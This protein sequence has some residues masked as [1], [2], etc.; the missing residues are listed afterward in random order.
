MRNLNSFCESLELYT[1][2]DD[3]FTNNKV[4]G[5]NVSHCVHNLA[6]PL[7]LA[8]HRDI[9]AFQV[10]VT[11]VYRLS[12]ENLFAYNDFFPFS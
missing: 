5:I 11:H 7:R 4:C 8:V 1:F 12:R 9:P 6:I 10:N 2:W 3:Y